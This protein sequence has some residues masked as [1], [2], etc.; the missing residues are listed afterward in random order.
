MANDAYSQQQLAVVPKF[1]ERVRGALSTV[2]WQVLNE[3][4]TVASHTDRAAFARQVLAN[5]TYHADSISSW[6]VMRP[7]VIAFDTTYDF[8]MGCLVT[9]SGD[10]DIESQLMTDWNDIAGIATP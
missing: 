10:A 6:L 1:R 2:A 5:T 4:D 8:P 3:A 9:A 7:N